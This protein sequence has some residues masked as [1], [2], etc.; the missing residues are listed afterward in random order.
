MVLPARWWNTLVVYIIGII[1]STKL[2]V[3][4]IVIAVAI[5]IETTYYEIVL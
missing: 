2:V 3:V 1:Q 5:K 4:V